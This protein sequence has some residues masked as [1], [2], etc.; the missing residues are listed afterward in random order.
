MF[1]D[2]IKQ[3]CFFCVVSLIIAGLAGCVSSGTET[4]VTS[5]QG[6]PDINQAQA[7]AYNGPKARVAVSRFK[8]KTHQGWYNQGIGDG[9]AD[10][11]TTALFNTNR[12]IVLERQA[13]SDVLE[14]QDLG[15]SGRIK[16][17]TAAAIGEIEGAEL[18]IVAAVT[19]F[20][21]HASGASGGIGGWGGGILGA[22]AG[23]MNKAHMAIDLRVI[24]A[25]TSR[26]VAATSVE[27]KSSD[28]NIGGAMGGLIGGGALG[29]SL[30]MYEKT[31]VGKAIRACIQS[32]VDF[33]VSKT[34]QT[35]YRH[36][37]AQPAAAPA[38]QTAPAAPASG[39]KVT[40]T[41]SALNMRSGPGTSNSI[42]TVLKG[43]EELTILERQGGWIK[44]KT[45][46]G[47]IGWISEKY[48]KPV[49]A[50]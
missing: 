37:A 9:M 42:V 19:E 12:Y 18:L 45:T 14:E 34:P 28:F 13:L 22:L 25:K 21:G 16:Q 7:E 41:V 8:D 23:G 35:Y 10:Q 46:S 30:G 48:T 15:A 20:E 5:G 40:I 43:G 2:R 17:D 39:E 31:P 33:I 32:A 49:P 50:G 3:I 36:G 26:I 1:M 38:V 44:V 6:S 29:G 27:G 24:D 47:T 11:L 4:K